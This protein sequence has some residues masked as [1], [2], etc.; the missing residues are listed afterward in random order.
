MLA[1]LWEPILAGALVFATLLMAGVVVATFLLWRYGRRKWRAFH[2]HG[3]VIGAV[4]LWEATARR[5]FRRRAPVTS[6]DMYRETPRQVRKELWRAVDQARAAVRAAADAGA[7][8]ASLPALCRRL[9][10]VAV[11]LDQVLRVESSGTVPR[12]VAEQVVE[13]VRAATDVQQA[14]VASASDA[15]GQRV[16]D[17]VRDAGQEIQCLDAGLASVRAALPPRHG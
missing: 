7:P 10:E 5:G 11:A 4:A 3:A 17:L 14:A 15:N 13:V 2:S 16:R 9:Q 1:A 12:E 8:T 6:E